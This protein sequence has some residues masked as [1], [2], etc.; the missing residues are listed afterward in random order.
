MVTSTAPAHEIWLRTSKDEI[1]AVPVG[2][3]SIDPA[4]CDDV[5][6]VVPV[7]AVPGGSVCTTGSVP[8]LQATPRAPAVA[9]SAI[10]T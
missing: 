9:A 6:P 1:V 4:P 10:A 7:P 5:V 2:S 8:L 3:R